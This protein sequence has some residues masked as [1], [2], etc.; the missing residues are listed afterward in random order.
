[1]PP[2]AVPTTAPLASTLRID[3]S[4]PFVL[5]ILSRLSRP[6]LLT[7]ANDWL[8]YGSS[9]LS[10]P[11]LCRPRDRRGTS[12]DDQ[13]EDDNLPRDH[14][15]DDSDDDEDDDDDDGDDDDG[16]R[17]MDPSDLYPPMRNISALRDHYASLRAR[18][19][20]RKELVD[21]IVEGDWRHGLSLYQIAMADL[22]Y[23][24]DHPGSQRWTAY[25]IVAHKVEL[26][27]DPEDDAPSTIADGQSLVVPRFHPST[28]LRN[29]QNQ[30]LPDVKVHFQFYRHPELPLLLLRV[31][32]LESP[33]NAVLGSTAAGA[34]DLEASR[35]V[36]IAFP[37]ASPHIYISKPQAQAS[38]ASGGSAE[39]KSLQML[40][41]RGIPQALSRPR[42][43]FG[44][45]HTGL[46]TRN[47]SELLERR[48]SGRTNC[49]AGGWTIYAD[50]M[51][52]GGKQESPLDTVQPTPPLSEM[53]DRD[54]PRSGK[55]AVSPAT[56]HERRAAKKA[57][58]DARRRFADSARID[59]GKGVE[60]LDVVI[61]DPFPDGFIDSRADGGQ[62]H[63]E[64]E[65]A[66]RR[67]GRRQGGEIDMA[68]GGQGDDV[69]GDYN[70]RQETRRSWRPHVTIAFQG[71]HVFAGIRQ[72][73]E[74]GIIDGRRM[75][76][77][78]TG[79]EGVTSGRVE[80]GRI[81][82]YS[83]SGV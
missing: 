56:E 46:T 70:V 49:A 75:P 73:V 39:S 57:V 34:S 22:Q 69:D 59:D 41:A 30:V 21:R 5:R 4:S 28:F 31:F 2:L 38:A 27:A 9:A 29:L 35:I 23:L 58:V 55:R 18:K 26:G 63:D 72:L 40:L 24:L 62:E 8:A 61:E 11:Y 7:L 60:R 48:G 78:M 10:G 20:T 1:M 44:L 52:L 43:R 19:G 80:D 71:P 74:H 15:H 82:G 64:E 13:A 67:D 76:G 47:L 50:E 68:T 66:Q 45:A 14:G 33:Y 17:D 81:K 3:P 77:W 32:V 51:G 83:G 65:Q 54:V 79:E 12:S 53:D 37:D 16:C 42:Q 6:S 25:R 36:Y